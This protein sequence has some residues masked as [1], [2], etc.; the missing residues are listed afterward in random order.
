MPGRARPQLRSCRTRFALAF[1]DGRAQML[2]CTPIRD[3]TTLGSARSISPQPSGSASFVAQ[4]VRSGA[5]D[6]KH[7]EWATMFWAARIE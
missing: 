1:P 2:L 5:Q 3:V 4:C 6:F 7:G